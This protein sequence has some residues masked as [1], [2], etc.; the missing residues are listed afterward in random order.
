[1]H[2][3]MKDFEIEVIGTGEDDQLAIVTRWGPPTFPGCQT[4]GG[5]FRALPRLPQARLLCRPLSQGLVDSQWLALELTQ[6]RSFLTGEANGTER[7]K[8]THSGAI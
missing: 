8:L 2:P 6:D 3:G 1:V 5:P 4:V 7:A